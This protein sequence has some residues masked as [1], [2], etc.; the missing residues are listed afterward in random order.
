MDNLRIGP[1][2]IVTNWAWDDHGGLS[3]LDT[4]LRSQIS[5]CDI[6]CGVSTI[7]ALDESPFVMLTSDADDHEGLAIARLDNGHNERFFAF[8]DA[9]PARSPG[10]PLELS[11]AFLTAW[12]TDDASLLATLPIPSGLVSALG[13][14][15]G[16]SWMSDCAAVSRSGGG[17][18]RVEVGENHPD[19]WVTL[20]HFDFRVELKDVDGWHITGGEQTL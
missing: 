20:A 3:W 8:G 14:V 19:H 7:E 4:R 6:D 1:R 9:L 17:I 11:G 5:S 13:P 15:P 10:R 16:D 18:C 12:A 2:S